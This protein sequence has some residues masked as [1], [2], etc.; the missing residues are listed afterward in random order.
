[1]RCVA[2]VLA[3]LL[4]VGCARA[5]SAPSPA[6]PS[7]TTSSSYRVIDATGPFWTFWDEASA[8][9]IADQ[10]RRFRELVVTKNPS[11]F[12]ESVV[13][14][15]TPED[16]DAQVER[17]LPTLPGRID[18]MRALTRSV[19]QDL[20]QHDATFRRAFP[21]MRWS[22]R[23]YFTVSLDAFDGAVRKVDG[24]PALA[25]GIDKIAKLHGRDANLAA[26]FHHELFHVYHDQ[27]AL[28][29][30]L[31]GR[32]PHGLLYPVWVEGLAVVAAKELNPGADAHALLL[33]REM[34]DGTRPKLADIARDLLAGLDDATE[35]TYRDFFLGRGKRADVPRRCGYLVGYVVA[36]RIV[37]AHGS[38]AAAARLR[39][40]ALHEEVAFVLRDL[41]AGGPAPEMDAL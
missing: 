17:W 16:L 8:L 39:S 34:I 6:R 41:A 35:E 24:E 21:D 4:V 28:E 36:R 9:P 20:A 27:V 2:C 13:G 25:F 30:E 37:A 22:G 1:M 15:K 14:E 40:P 33:S 31:H 29:A 26:L 10:R 7:A 38:V 18:A 32:D 11:L 3:G 23:V 5:P 12:A 19:R